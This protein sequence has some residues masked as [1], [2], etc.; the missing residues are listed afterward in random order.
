MKITLTMTSMVHDLPHNNVKR[1]NGRN[2]ETKSSLRVAN[3][4]TG[5]NAR[6]TDD[7]SNRALHPA[8]QQFKRP[9]R[10][11]VETSRALLEPESGCM[12]NNIF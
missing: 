8:H 9:L 5:S 6:Y 4:C 3:I 12:M 2:Q 7:K 10:I 11:R 1:H